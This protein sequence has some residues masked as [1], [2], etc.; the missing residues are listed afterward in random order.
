M[1]VIDIQRTRG[2][3]AEPKGRERFEIQIAQKPSRKPFFLGFSLAALVLFMKSA[4]G[5]S[6]AHDTAG[7]HQGPQHNSHSPNLADDV[8]VPSGEQAS[9]GGAEPTK[10]SFETLPLD[11]SA[12]KGGAKYLSSLQDPE[13]SFDVSGLR[14]NSPLQGLNGNFGGAVRFP[15][16]AQ[17]DNSLPVV[18]G[19]VLADVIA[20]RS[21]SP[22]QP[23]ATRTISQ[24]EANNH[25]PVSKGPVR[26]ADLYA[27]DIAAI[28]VAD[29]LL[30]FTD[31]DAT[32]SLG[33]LN[34]TVNGEALAYANGRFALPA[35]VSGPI[36]INYQVSDGISLVEAK[37]TATVL[38][39]P[40][41]TG[42]ASD[43]T[44]NGTNHSDIITGGD[45]KDMIDGKAGDDVINAGCGSDT[46]FGGDGKD[47][48]NGGNGNDTL[49]G[50]AGDD[51]L[52]G[53]SGN[54]RLFGGAGN[55]LLNGG[56]GRDWIY[57]GVGTDK[58]NA[59]SGNDTVI[60]EADLQN[61]IFDGGTGVDKVSYAIGAKSIII[62]L[63]KGTATGAD[64]GT[65]ALQNFEIFQGGKAN[66]TFIAALNPAPS[67]TLLNMSSSVPVLAEDIA[68][69]YNP[70]ERN[71][72]LPPT[73][74]ADA[75]ISFDPASR[76]QVAV[77]AAVG[78]T[79]IGGAGVNTL[80]YTAAKTTITINMSHGT[81][82]GSQLNGDYFEQMQNFSTGS[83]DDQFFAAGRGAQE[84]LHI[85]DEIDT[86]EPDADC[87]GEAVVD[88]GSNPVVDISTLAPTA[89]IILQNQTYSGG[90]G[91]DTLSYQDADNSVTIDIS[92]GK[93]TGS[94]IGTDIF[95]GI[96]HFIGGNGADIFTIG[97][98]TYTLEGGA[99]NDEFSFV[100]PTHQSANVQIAGF[101]VGD[102]VRIVKYDLFEDPTLTPDQNFQAVYTSN[103]NST[104]NQTGIDQVTPIHVR[105][106]V[107]EGV[108]K[109][110]IEADLDND[111]NVDV[112]VLL[113]GDHHLHIVEWQVA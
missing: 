27:N 50:N 70:E 41:F 37:A 6:A 100:T 110:Y 58:V 9:G 17:N 105:H 72:S 64:I 89:A 40:T 16:T 32:D 68:T 112:S 87:D 53:G 45:G 65:D 25:A 84:H 83:G 24:R 49:Y 107:V 93:A 82:T 4:L 59:G 71:Q 69:S 78:N 66:D 113:E 35:Q 76:S 55:D 98:G 61:D 80:D 81:A 23:L 31:Q 21:S 15:V 5:A 36:D 62:D 102:W 1:T 60:A 104:G 47:V 46:I 12:P 96:E 74:A 73:M 28:T 90:A 8:T 88:S 30:N 3:D 111:G 43:D 86:P 85:T 56:S 22:E 57:D 52:S 54:D 11:F 67:A 44:L 26:L 108:G 51:V 99:G 94:E 19:K 79:F 33:V 10:Q 109:T 29:L 77:V 63:V 91:Y 95:S 34:V 106:E 18:T 75:A 42:S 2:Q 92:Q 7:G 48:I 20:S 101:E 39:Q 97:G 13:A 103:D 38:A 14:Y